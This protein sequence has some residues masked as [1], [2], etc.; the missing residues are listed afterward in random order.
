MS[1]SSW[2]YAYK[3]F[4]EVAERLA[5]ERDPLRVA[6]GRHLKL[7]ARALH[8]IEWVDSCDYGVGAEAEAI[9]A[10]LSAS[11]ST[12]AARRTLVV[13]SGG[14]TGADQAGLSA[15]R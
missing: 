15:A 4:E 14:Q 12:P 3:K 10:V 13:I 11:M 9:R 1:G 2:D 7:V 5:A 6:L 8:D